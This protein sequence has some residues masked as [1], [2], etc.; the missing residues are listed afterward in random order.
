VV[1]FRT[2]FEQRWG[3]WFVTGKHGTAL[4]RGN[5]I[6][7]EHG[8]E[9]VADFKPGAN[10]TNLAKFFDTSTYL[11]PGSDIVALLVFEH[12]LA[13]Q[14]ALTQAGFRSRRMLAYQKDLQTAFK[15]PITEEPA[16]DSVKSVFASV[17]RDVLDCLLFKGE[18]TLPDGIE[19]APEFQRAF[20]ADARIAADSGSLKDLSLNQ[21]LFKNRCSYLIYSESFLAL[22]KLLKQRIYDGLA[23]ALRAENPDSRYAYL[24]A[25]ERGRI[26][27]I[28]KATHPELGSK[29]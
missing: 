8:D 23:A 4:H 2:P 16:Y 26:R 21:R 14:N 3:G 25:D 19:G 27:A 28:L 12:Q 5:T 13:T 7:R 1:D 22:P 24:D 9:L 29:W 6:S 17:T 18:A 20:A 10:V 15:E 11:Q